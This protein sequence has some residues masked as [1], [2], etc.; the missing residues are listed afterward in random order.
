MVT[1][2]CPAYVPKHA[3]EHAEHEDKS[4][5]GFVDSSIALGHPDNGPVTGASGDEYCEDDPKEASQIRQTLIDSTDICVSRKH[6][7]RSDEE[8]HDLGRVE[9]I[10]NGE[11]GGRAERDYGC[12][13]VSALRREK[14]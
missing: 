12:F 4:V 1:S 7:L 11:D 9:V 6:G 5:L 10:L 14:R 2:D 13:G 3:D 8:T